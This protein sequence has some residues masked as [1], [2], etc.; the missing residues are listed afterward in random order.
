MAAQKGMD[1]LNLSLGGGE[2]AWEEVKLIGQGEMVLRVKAN[3][4]SQD[5]LAVALSNIEE[6]GIV[7][8]V[9]QGNEGKDEYAIA[10]NVRFSAQE[11]PAPVV[12]ATGACA[13]LLQNLKQHVVLVR[14]G[15]CGWGQMARH[16]QNAGGTVMLVA[17][18]LT[19]D[20]ISLRDRTRV[21]IPVVVISSADGTTIETL[22]KS[23]RSAVLEFATAL[24]RVKTAG[25]VSS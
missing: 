3:T 20:T 22:L 10:S 16:V 17:A 12:Q 19:K 15:N 14:P 13:P 2:S 8:V 21:R 9:A 18:D 11:G 5:A 6:K 23:E 24:V 1:I 25:M 4:V 7:V